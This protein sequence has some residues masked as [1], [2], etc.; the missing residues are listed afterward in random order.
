MQTSGLYP[1]I[2]AVLPCVHR[3]CAYAVRTTAPF[4]WS[5]T[6]ALLICIP[7]NQPSSYR[8][9]RNLSS[10]Q[11][12]SYLAILRCQAVNG[13]FQTLERKPIVLA[14]EEKKSKSHKDE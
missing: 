10:K 11:Q 9:K 4:I 6:L 1:C 14:I 2:Q 7:S 12:A 8:R 3:N 13:E 5:W